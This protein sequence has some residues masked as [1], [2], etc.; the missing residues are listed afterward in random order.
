MVARGARAPPLLAPPR[1]LFTNLGEKLSEKSWTC[2]W[3]SPTGCREASFGPITCSA[4]RPNSRLE[5]FSNPFRTVSPRTRVYKTKKRGRPPPRYAARPAVKIPPGRGAGA[6]GS[7]TAASGAVLQLEG[8]HVGAVTAPR[9]AD[10][11]Q[12]DGAR[13][14]A[15]I[16]HEAAIALV[17][18]RAAI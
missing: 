2:S 18:G 12:V 17:Q 5:R 16:S 6:A 7:R 8:S 13:L 4:Y 10:V 14:A 11:G 15:L 3:R 9:V 1:A